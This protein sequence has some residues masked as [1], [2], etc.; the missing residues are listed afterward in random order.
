MKTDKLINST[1]NTIGQDLDISEITQS[2][3]EG[4][5]FLNIRTSDLGRDVKS[6]T[7]TIRPTTEDVMIDMLQLPDDAGYVDYDQYA[8]P[9]EN[10]GAL[11]GAV[12]DQL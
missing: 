10:V 6:I 4:H 7:V 8:P 9:I 1:L 11:V 5:V 12:D 3:L 2:V